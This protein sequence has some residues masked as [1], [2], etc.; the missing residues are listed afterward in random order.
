MSEKI[1]TGG[2][3]F[4]MQD[5]QAIHAYAAAAI[6]HLPH[7]TDERDRTYLAARTQAVSGLTARDYFAAKAMH[8]IMTMYKPTIDGAALAIPHHAE[9]VADIAYAMADAMLKAREGGAE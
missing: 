2:P 3:A 9:Q 1:N 5:A 8:G 7:N 6:Q 4:P